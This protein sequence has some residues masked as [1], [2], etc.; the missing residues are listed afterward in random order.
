MEPPLGCGTA[1]TNLT[2]SVRI[3]PL[4]VLFTKRYNGG[5]SVCDDLILSFVDI[6]VCMNSKMMNGVVSGTL[7]PMYRIN[8]LGVLLLLFSFPCSH[9]TIPTYSAVGH[10]LSYMWSD[11]RTAHKIQ[12]HTVTGEKTRQICN[13]IFS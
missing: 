13:A 8:K 3:P 10:P 5:V 11:T 12:N 2:F 1:L 7:L 4:H 9:H 6:L